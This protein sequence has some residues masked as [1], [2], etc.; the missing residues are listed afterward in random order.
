MVRGKLKKKHLI[1]LSF[2]TGFYFLLY[3]LLQCLKPKEIHFFF[4]FGCAY[5]YHLSG[6]STL[7]ATVSWPISALKSSSFVCLP[8]GPEN[9]ENNS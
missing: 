6:L 2:P 3:S 7:N 9:M 8:R 4:K 1:F 5:K